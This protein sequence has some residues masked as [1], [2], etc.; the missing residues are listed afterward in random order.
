MTNDLTLTKTTLAKL[1]EEIRQMQI[2]RRLKAALRREP[3]PDK[4]AVRADIESGPKV[5]SLDAFR[6]WR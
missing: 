4:T 3:R 5:T 2:K 1:K 6:A